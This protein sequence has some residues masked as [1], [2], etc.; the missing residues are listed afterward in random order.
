LLNEEMKDLHRVRDPRPGTPDA[1]GLGSLVG[2]LR[3]L[4]DEG[5]HVVVHCRMGIGRSSLIAAGVLVDGDCL[6]MRM[7]SDSS[8]QG[9]PVPDTEHQ[10]IWLRDAT[11]TP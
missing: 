7:V 2:E 3:A 4:L 8:H 9:L 11:E 10:R 5:T 6:P 1:S